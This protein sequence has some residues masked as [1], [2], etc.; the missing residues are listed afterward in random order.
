MK[1]RR[2]SGR[3]A[4]RPWS[5]ETKSTVDWLIG[6]ERR[7]RTD[8]TIHAREESQ[9]AEDDAQTKTK[10]LKYLH[11]VNRTEFER[12]NVADDVFKAGIGWLELGISEDPDDEPLYMRA[13]SWRNMLYDSLGERRDTTDWRYIF[14]FRMVD[15]DMAVAYFPKGS[16]IARGGRGIGQRQLPGVVERHRHV[17]HRAGIANARQVRYVRL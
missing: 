1:R 2:F 10:L 17:G 12:S 7:T 14:R 11:D 16:R 6:T 5:N 3:A 13:E 4:R 8:F 9:A 15:L